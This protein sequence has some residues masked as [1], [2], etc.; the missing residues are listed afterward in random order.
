MASLNIEN[1]ISIFELTESDNAK[2]YF[3]LQEGDYATE[4]I[5]EGNVANKE[6]VTKTGN[7][8]RIFG[9][10]NDEIEEYM[11]GTELYF[12]VRATG[13]Q[14]EAGGFS[15][16]ET[17]HT[18]TDGLEAVLSFP[19]ANQIE[20]E[21]FVSIEATT[22][23]RDQCVDIYIND[24]FLDRYLVD[25]NSLHFTIPREMVPDKQLTIRFGLP[26]ATSAGGDTRLMSLAFH[27]MK[28]TERQENDTDSKVIS[29]SYTLGNKITFTN[30]TNGCNYFLYGISHIEGD[31]AWSL[32]HS[33]KIMIPIAEDTGD[34]A[35]EWDF[36]TIYCKP[37]RFIVRCG[38]LTLYDTELSAEKHI[39]FSIPGSCVIDGWL[40][41]D[42]EYPNAVSPWARGE[43]E[44]ARELAFAFEK[45]RFYP[46]EGI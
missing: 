9:R 46:K 41:L 11:L 37:Q 21:V 15:K 5:V 22:I 2:R 20:Q 4:Y 19:L 16:V 28:I 26:N 13:T 42:L 12:D 6:N 10:E 40:T 7:A 36:K 33:G 14:Y 25:E 34:L 38:D 18:W 43:S 23:N 24:V 32:G 29:H 27:S 1:G 17:T 44:D 35:C 8:F 39:Q 45:I 3:Y 30:D 31:F